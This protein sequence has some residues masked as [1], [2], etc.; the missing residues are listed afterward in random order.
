M[1]T[2]LVEPVVSEKE[3]KSKECEAMSFGM[4]FAERADEVQY[5]VMGLTVVPTQCWSDMYTD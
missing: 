3:T 4:R 2:A 1:E 5:R